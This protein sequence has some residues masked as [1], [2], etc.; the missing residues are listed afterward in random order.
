MS[1][2]TIS[3]KIHKNKLVEIDAVCRRLKISRSEF[4]RTAILRY[5]NNID[6]ENKKFR[7][8]E[9]VLK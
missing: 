3:F 7:V 5:I 2:V 1:D 6:K 9:V 8:C 4:I